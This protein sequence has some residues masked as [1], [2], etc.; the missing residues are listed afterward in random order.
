[1]VKSV[2]FLTRYEHFLP[3]GFLSN[4]VGSVVLMRKI[5]LDELVVCFH[6]H[7][8]SESTIMIWWK[9]ETVVGEKNSVI[10]KLAQFRLLYWILLERNCLYN[11]RTRRF[12]EIEKDN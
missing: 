6:V 12:V 4:L 1:M 3:G 7:S 2:L 9:L 10:S 8:L 5:T 11:F